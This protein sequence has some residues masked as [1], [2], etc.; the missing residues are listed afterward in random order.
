M[1]VCVCAYAFVCVIVCPK[2]RLF[3]FYDEMGEI[4]CTS[5]EE[6]IETKFSQ[7]EYAIRAYTYEHRDHCHDEANEMRFESFLLFFF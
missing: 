2:S 5:E 7:S 4:R 6:K 3:F 1:C